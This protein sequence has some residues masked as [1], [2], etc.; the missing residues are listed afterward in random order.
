MDS[1]HG[2]DTNISNDDSSSIIVCV[3]CSVSI[4]AF[5]GRDLEKD[6]MSETSGNF[7]RLLVTM[8]QVGMAGTTRGA[9]T[10][11]SVLLPSPCRVHVM[12]L[13]Q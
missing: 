6:V 12:S 4:S 13:L 7:K 1:T 10:I 2:V 3:T 11:S 8:C 9:Q 5:P